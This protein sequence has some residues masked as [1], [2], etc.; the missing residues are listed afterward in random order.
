MQHTGIPTLLPI[1]YSSQE[2]QKK[3]S[4]DKYVTKKYGAPE[5]MSARI[6][7]QPLMRVCRSGVELTRQLKE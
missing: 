1:S 5:G 2:G 7:L 6:H 3:Y 4:T